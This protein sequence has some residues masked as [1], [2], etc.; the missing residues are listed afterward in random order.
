VTGA[1]GTTAG[2]RKSVK[3]VVNVVVEV[4][5]RMHASRRGVNVVQ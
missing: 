4:M 1:A 2:G 5:M 3:V